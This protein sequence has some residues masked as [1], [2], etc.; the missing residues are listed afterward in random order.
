MV[1]IGNEKVQQA[2]QC[3]LDLGMVITRSRQQGPGRD[4][5]FFEVHLIQR[6]AIDALAVAHAATVLAETASGGAWRM[7]FKLPD[8]L[9]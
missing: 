9:F 2:L 4:Q 6:H 7:S 8:D 3:S 5:Q 1:M